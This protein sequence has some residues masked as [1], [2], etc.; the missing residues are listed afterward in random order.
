M[1]RWRTRR[2]ALLARRSRPF[3]AA[4]RRRA[5]RLPRAGRRVLQAPHRHGAARADPRV[6]RAR[7]SRA[8]PHRRVDHLG[9]R[10]GH[11]GSRAPP[12]RD[13]HGCAVLRPGHVGRRARRTARGPRTRDR[14]VR[15]VRA[16]V[17]DREA[18][19]FSIPRHRLACAAPGRGHLPARAL[20][21]RD[22]RVRPRD[23]ARC[24][25]PRLRRG[26]RGG[27]DG[28]RHVR[29]AP[30]RAARDRGDRRAHP[31]V[32][33]APH[34]GRRHPRRRPRRRRHRAVVRGAARLDRRCAVGR[35]VRGPRARGRVERDAPPRRRGAAAR[36][37][38]GRLHARRRRAA[39]PPSRR[40]AARAAR[41]DA[42]GRCDPPR[43]GGLH[44]AP[45]EPRSHPALP[46]RA[47]LDRRARGQDA[48]PGRRV[49]DRR[50]RTGACC[51]RCTRR[52]SRSS[53]G[54][55]A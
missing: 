44:R 43:G 39:V 4:R 24:A 9:L 48:G 13:P 41:L 5:E 53:R 8:G 17:A 55:C 7:R 34:R 20:R 42:H 6:A 22:E 50:S 1:L 28:G 12:R 3:G 52:R 49:V 54:G 23:G 11:R 47:R 25:R 37:D 2:V 32:G 51:S 38:P 10:R 27:R 46:Q 29:Q 40:R 26:R 14:R 16:P 18:L 36:G 30:A 15:R 35:D 21:R 45:A 33:R 31:P 19:V